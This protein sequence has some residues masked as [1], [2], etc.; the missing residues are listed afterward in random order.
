MKSLYRIEQE[1][2][3]ILNEIENNDGEITESIEEKLVINENEFE[4]KSINYAYII[5]SINDSKLIIKQE[6]DRL[7]NLLEKENKKEE[8]LKS[9][10]VSAMLNFNIEKVESPT[11]KLSIRKS[12]AINIIDEEAIES[13]YIDIKEVSTISKTRLKEAIKAGINVKG[14]EL[15]INHNLQ[16][17]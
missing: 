6:I 11:L 1:Y 16:I 15:I 14:A 12:E 8:S 3:N 10:L 4:L 7:R 2:L 13:D 17:K 5:K 9:N